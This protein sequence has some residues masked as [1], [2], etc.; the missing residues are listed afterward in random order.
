MKT[1]ATMVTRCYTSQDVQSPHHHQ[2]N[3]CHH[4]HLR[5]KPCQCKFIEKVS[6]HMPPDASPRIFKSLDCRSAICPS[7]RSTTS[8][9]GKQPLGWSP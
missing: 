3:K 2:S 1:S 4:E 7:T 9:M 5:H 6:H 8:T